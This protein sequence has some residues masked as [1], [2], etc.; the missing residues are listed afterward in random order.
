MRAFAL[1]MAAGCAMNTF[2]GAPLAQPPSTP[3]APAVPPPPPAPPAALPV[4]DGPVVK[5]QEIDGIII[6]DIT[7]G[8]GYE[9]PPGGAVVAHYHGTLKDGTVFDSSFQRGEPVPFGLSGVIQGWQKGVPGMK[10]GGVRRLTVPA[11]LAYG[12]QSPPGSGIPANSDLIFVIQ[13]LDAMK[14]E[15][16]KVGDGEVAT[17]SCIPVTTYS[18]LDADGKCIEKVEA[19]KAYVWLPGEYQPLLLGIEGMKVGGKRKLVVPKEMNITP[20]QAQSARPQNI[21]VTIEV[22]LVAVR[23]MPPRRR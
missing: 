9:V 7:I 11:A 14:V 18:I 19:S 17:S 16:L 13:L 20:P 2:A 23:N 15:D 4:P 6:E 21:P 10:V 22:E 1:V 3:P 12:A 8:D 5:K